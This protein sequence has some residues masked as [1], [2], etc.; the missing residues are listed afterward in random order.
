MK[1][2]G[3]FSSMLRA[4]A[5]SPLEPTPAVPSARAWVSQKEP[6]RATLVGVVVAAILLLVAAIG[7]Y[8]QTALPAAPQAQMSVPGGYSVH[9]SIDLGGR[10]NNTSGSG[11]MYDTM[12]NLQSGPRVLGETFR[13][14]ALPGAKNT[15]LDDL[16][17][18]A[19][20]FGGDPNNFA[21]LDF[22]KS[23][24]YEFSGMFRRDRQYFDYDL[25]GNPNIPGGQSIALSPSGSFA[26]PQVNQSPFLFNT[27]RRM[28]DTNLTLLPLSKL[29]FRVG[30]SQ[31]VMQGPSI[32]PSGYQISGAYNPAA[33]IPWISA[34]TS[35]LLEEYQRNST[36]D[37]LGAA[38]WKPIRDTRLTF[39]EQIAHYKGDSY[40]TM[41]PAFF[42][43]QEA[44]GTPVAFLI[45][46]DS[47]TPYAKSSCNTAALGANPMLSV[48]VN[49]IAP[50]ID[51]ACSVISSYFRAQPTRVIIPTE[52]I[53]F[54]STSIKNFSMNGD[55]RYTNANMNLPSYYESFAGL[56]TSNTAGYLATTADSYQGNGTAKREV[57][58]FDYGIVWQATKSVAIEDQINYSNVHQPGIAALT[59]GTASVTATGTPQTINSTSQTAETAGAGAAPIEGSPAIGP[60]SPAYAAYFGQMFTTN[61][62]T[63]SWDATPRSTFSLTYRYQDHLISEG[64]GTAAHNVPIPANNTTSGEV[65]IHENGGIFTAALRPA[66]NWDINGSVEAMYND[67]AFTPMGFRQLRHYRVHTIYRP[68]SW[69]TVSG[70]FNDLER[71]NNT[72]NNQSIPGNTTPYAGPL[73][74]VDHSRVGSFGAELFPNDTYG[75]DLNYS[76]SDVYMADNICYLGS[77]SAALPGAAIPSGTACPNNAATRSG[78]YDFG[79]ARD[80]MDAPSQFGSVAFKYSPVKQV[81]SNLGYRITSVNGT[82]F[83][84]DPR[85]VA[86]SL[87]STYQTPFVDLS[88]QSR[89]GLTWKAD[90]S[91]FGYGE[92]G[93]SGAQYCSTTN[94]TPTSPVTPVPCSSLGSVVGTG[95]QTG[96]TISPAGETAPRNFHAN[97]VLVGVH[98]EF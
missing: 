42:R 93:P 20:G 55:V 10:I 71:H 7:A 45:N 4:T 92:G 51:P 28:T 21:K 85:D 32:T 49:G 96:L 73:D 88:W 81:H 3:W 86:G 48:P 66:N 30:Y 87:V 15:P 35:V 64:Q 98:Y 31:N 82:R 37:F 54:Q 12:V 23:K 68:K 89:P 2:V 14:H 8:G 60:A 5:D 65:T 18:F 27:V 39:E 50:V 36:D 6:S 47:L 76:Y 56:A 90:Y 97:N 46:Y 83:Y 9:E 19:S 26:W 95:G 53:R 62:F 16:R 57:M 38:D 33:K 17:A 13:L 58:A 11:A 40:F 61:N 44:D 72:N 70:V 41:D 79:P 91:F 84:N 25:L 52:I 75:L 63:V 59:G 94:P 67:N 80:F 43:A 78:T 22:S 29:S 69:A 24:Y 34:G 1:N 74:H 77:A